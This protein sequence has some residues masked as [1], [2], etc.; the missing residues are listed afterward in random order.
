MFCGHL[1]YCCLRHL[2]LS[3]YPIVNWG[4]LSVLEGSRKEYVQ[5]FAHILS[6]QPRRAFKKRIWTV[7]KPHTAQWETNKPKSNQ[8]KIAVDLNLYPIRR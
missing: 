8:I 2:S 4:A 5:S 7:S 1:Q 6:Q 3:L